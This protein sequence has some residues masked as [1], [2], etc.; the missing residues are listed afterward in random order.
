LLLL[1]V[2]IHTAITTSLADA[3]QKNTTHDVHNIRHICA[4]VLSIANTTQ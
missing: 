1:L 2:P 4:E 3:D